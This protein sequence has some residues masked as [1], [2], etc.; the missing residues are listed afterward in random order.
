MVNVN[1][2]L[3]LPTPAQSGVPQRYVIG[4]LLFV[5]YITDLP[6][7]INN[8]VLMY[9]DDVKLIAPRFEHTHLQESLDQITAWSHT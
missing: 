9:A 7:V 5:I 2:Q 3:S 6:E 1:E 8:I 4:P